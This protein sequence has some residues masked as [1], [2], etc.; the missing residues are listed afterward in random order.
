MEF[1]IL[2]IVFDSFLLNMIDSNI[3]MEVICFK[4]IWGGGGVSD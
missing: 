3:R 2:Y 4:C 1:L